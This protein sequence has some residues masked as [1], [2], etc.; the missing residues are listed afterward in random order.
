MGYGQFCP[1]A[2]TMEILDERWTVLV[3]RELLVGS[4]HFNELRRGVPKMSPALLSK[5]LRSLERAGLVIRQV[6]GNRIR[7]ELSP[8]GKELGPIV[9]SLGEWGVRWRS[10]LGDE[11]LDPMLLMW[12]V[13]RNLN[14]EAFPTGRTVLAF[15]FS[16]VEPRTRDWRLVVT[17][18]EVDVCDFDPGFPVAVTSTS[19]LRT[20]VDI[21]RGTVPWSRALRSGAVHLDG[22]SAACRALP[23]WLR[24]SPFAPQ[25]AA[26]TAHS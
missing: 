14:L 11:D 17:S 5:R 2:K 23:D 12:D 7:Y 8:G 18:R 4:H 6:D 19:T 26:L 1:I 16:D 21:W 22:S 3:L 9:M 15:T 24:L 20:M 25:A 13:H 10:Q